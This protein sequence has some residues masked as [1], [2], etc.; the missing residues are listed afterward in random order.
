MQKRDFQ[1]PR[2][3][4]TAPVPA[5]F[6]KE[7]LCTCY[8]LS[9]SFS[10]PSKDFW[11]IRSSASQ[12]LCCYCLRLV[13]GALGRTRGDEPTTLPDSYKYARANTPV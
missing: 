5:V 2:K 7:L 8:I 12:P 6:R 1:F 3:S 10:Q 9:V 4:N 13:K 11:F